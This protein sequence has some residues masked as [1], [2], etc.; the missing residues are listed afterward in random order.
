MASK[1][2][3]RL[4]GDAE[5][6]QD[7]HVGGGEGGR[8]LAGVAQEADALATQPIVDVGIVD[9]LAG[10]EDPP[11]GELEPRL[12]GV[13]DG[14]IDAVAEPE[15]AGQVHGEPAR[16][17]AVVVGLDRGDQRAVVV[18]GQLAGDLALEVEA[19]LEDE[20]RHERDYR[21]S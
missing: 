19:L 15:L 10:E 21:I 8:R 11:V 16:R 13:V 5:G 18:L 14:A 17:V 20:R 6:R 9:D 7:D 4:D 1:R 12:V 2:G 3:E